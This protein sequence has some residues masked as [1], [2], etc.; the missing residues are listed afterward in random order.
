MTEPSV[1]LDDAPERV[2][3][4]LFGEALRHVLDVEL[5]RSRR[6][7]SPFVLLRVFLASLDEHT[8]P[9]ASMRRKLA[10]AVRSA[11]RWADTVGSEGD[12]SLLIILR[13]TEAAGADAVVEKIEA[14]TAEL[15]Q[16]SALN[17]VRIERA[18][19]RKGDDLEKLKGRFA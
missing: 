12:G 3:G 17:P 4:V 10:G 15:L 5:A 9:D 11:T 7:D 1:R 2:P 18:V 16:E 19:W 13:E 6:Y 8:A 14:R